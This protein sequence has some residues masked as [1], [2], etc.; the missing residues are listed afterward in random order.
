MKKLIFVLLI[1]MFVSCSEKGVIAKINGKKI[2][3]KYFSQELSKLPDSLRNDLD[4]DSLAFLDELIS[5]ELLLQEAH[6]F[7]IDTINQVK[8]DITKD[9]SQRDDILIQKL[10]EQKCL[11]NIE[12]TDD[13]ITA[14][15]NNNILD[16]QGMTL[17]QEKQDIYELLME[18]KEQ[19]AIGAY[20]SKLEDKSEIIYY[21][22]WSQND[23]TE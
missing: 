6:R 5:N 7:K 18:Q 19:A 23:S 14:F 13:E 2:T 20:I 22:K 16:M 4:N 11:S 9:E 10:L 15:Y 8:N 12:V 1:I 17:E 21:V 3:L